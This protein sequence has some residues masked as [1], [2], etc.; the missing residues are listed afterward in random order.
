MEGQLKIERREVLKEK[1][2]FSRLGFG[3]YFTDH[4]LIIDY[5]EGKGWHDARIVPYAPITLDPAAMV[6]H[7]GQTVFEGLKAFKTTDNRVLLFRP[8]KNFA[9]LNRSNDRLTIPQIDEEQVLEALKALISLEKDWIPTE[10]GTSLYIRPF[11][12]ATEPCLG[13]RASHEY[14]LMVILSPVGAYYAEGLEPVHI[15][16]E[17]K[18]VRAVRGGTGAA[19]TAGNYASSIKAQVEA[20]ESGYSQV[21]WLDGIEQRYI[22]EV[23]SMNVFFKIDGQVL[24][25]ELNGS[26]LDGVTRDSIITLLKEWGIPVVER[27][28]SIEELHE[29]YQNGTFEEAFGTGTAA[30]I[31]PIGELNWLNHKMIINDGKIGELSQKLYDTITG[32]QTGKLAD[33]FHWVVEVN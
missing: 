24:T 22:E 32:I 1:P 29:A 16:V 27:K 25:P 8:E 33:P 28:L 5:K 17:S 6:F 7:Y 23:G 4:M 11:I 13:V 26:I 10:P 21:L 31:S 12:I 18:Y 30:V 2:D 14:K 19:K 15:N 9:R 3:Q 20:K